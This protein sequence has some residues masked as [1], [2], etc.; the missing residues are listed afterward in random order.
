MIG[1][2]LTTTQTVL[3]YSNGHGDTHDKVQK[4]VIKKATRVS[5]P[6]ARPLGLL[7][8]DKGTTG[9]KPKDS[10][11]IGLVD[12]S[13][14]A[15][16]YSYRPRRTPAVQ[17]RA[18]NTHEIQHHPLPHSASTHNS[19]PMLEVKASE[20]EQEKAVEATTRPGLYSQK[21]STPRHL[22]RRGQVWDR[23][24]TGDSFRGDEVT[25]GFALDL[26]LS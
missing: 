17:K 5:N 1:M 24:E 20:Q 23:V 2:A 19:V 22:R 6:T 21:S 12:I 8:I 9:I 3:N 15:P 25:K 4:K 13:A 18:T 16:E 26:G 7:Q 14:L 11:L 10:D